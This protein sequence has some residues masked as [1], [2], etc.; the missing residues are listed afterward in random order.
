MPLPSPLMAETLKTSRTLLLVDDDVNVIS[1]LR[2]TLRRDGYTILSANS[3]K[4]GLNL[5]ANHEV[6]VVISDQR[7][8]HMTGVE[9]FS[10]VK[11]LYPKTLRII[12]SGY[13][14]LKSVTDAINQGSIYKFSTKPWD[15]DLLRD[16]IREAFQYYEMEQENTRLSRELQSANNKLFTLNQN[17]EQKVADKTREIIHSINVLQISQEILEHL[18]IGIIGIDEQHMIV[19]SNRFTEAL[20]DQPSGCLLGLM[21][22]DVLPETLLRLLPDIYADNFAPLDGRIITLSDDVSMQIFIRRI[23]NISLSKNIILIL[24]PLMLSCKN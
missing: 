15:D 23:G 24:T 21:A 22:E 2:R 3:G 14:E 4:E 6:G 13:T 19:V 17:L 20:F 10:Q 16:N 9:F 1:A 8:P 5:L 11:K 12:L 7:M 18:P